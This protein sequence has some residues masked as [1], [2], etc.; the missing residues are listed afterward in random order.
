MLFYN[1]I[2]RFIFKS[3]RLNYLYSKKFLT[4]IG[5]AV[6]LMIFAS[7]SNGV[8]A[9]GFWQEEL[10][11]AQQNFEEDK[12]LLSRYRLAISRANTG[13]LQET[14]E[15]I[16]DFAEKF[17]INKLEQEIAFELRLAELGSENL[18]YL[19]YAA[20]FYSLKENHQKSV[21]FFSRISEVDNSNIWPLNYKALTLIEELKEYERALEVL[22]EALNIEENDY[23]YLLQG[24]AHYRQG[25][26][27]RAINSLRQGRSKLDELEEKWWLND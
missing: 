23:I 27:L 19:N 17:D 12:T 24:L 22:D 13:Y 4:L 6:F 26:Y 2:F 8:A 11:K 14:Y 5:L 18:M 3:N 25:N 15:M 9:D 16:D 20:F 7:V 1:F 10:E 21:E